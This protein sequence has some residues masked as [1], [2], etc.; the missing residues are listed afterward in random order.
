MALLRSLALAVVTAYP[1]LV[2]YGGSRPFQVAPLRPAGDNFAPGS[3]VESSRVSNK[4][5]ITVVLMASWC[6]ICAGLIDEL[7]ASPGSRGKLDMIVFFEDENG[8]EAKQGRYIQHPEK[9]AG[10]DL[11]YY[12]AKG[13]D[14]EG[15]YLG[16]PTILGCT[17]SG[18]TPRDRTAIGLE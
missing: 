14:F 6:P 12:L 11:P 2:G 5:E 8:D 16:F 7:A 9:L 13:K 10:R 3:W 4:D 1:L 15:L 18:C 17:Q